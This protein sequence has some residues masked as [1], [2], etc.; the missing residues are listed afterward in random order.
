MNRQDSYLTLAS[1]KVPPFHILTCNYSAMPVISKEG[2]VGGGY[3]GVS[4]VGVMT[5]ER[6]MGAEHIF[7]FSVLT[8]Y[9][10]NWSV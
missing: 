5:R 8:I 3:S 10:Y 7:A 6:N 1:V 9:N 4:T 2:G